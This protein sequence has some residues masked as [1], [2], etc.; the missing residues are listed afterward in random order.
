MNIDM[1][2]NNSICMRLFYYGYGLAL[3][4]TLSSCTKDYIDPSRALNEEALSSSQALTDISIGLQRTYSYL[5][6]SN[7]YN[8]VTA[9]GFVTNELLLRNEGNIPELQ[10]STGGSTVDGTNT[11]LAGLWTSSNK[12]IYDA[13]LVI[14]NA[15]KLADKNRASGIIAYTTVLKA[16]S[17]GDLAI[18]W[19]QVPAT[20]GRNASFVDRMEGYR[21][22]ISSI[23]SALLFTETDSIS[24][25][26]LQDIPAASIDIKNTL[27]ALK[28]RYSLYIGDYEEALSAASQVDLKK[29]SVFAYDNVSPNPIY[30][31]A[32]STNNVFQPKDEHLGLPEA[33][34][35]D[36]NDQR[37]LFYIENANPAPPAVR[38]K[39]FWFTNESPIP[40]YLPGEMLLIKAEAYARTS[41]LDLALIELNKVITKKPNDDV[42]GLGAA[43]PGLTGPY[44]E[45]ELLTLIY[46]HRCIELFMSGLKLEDMRRFN[47]PQTEMKRNF[48]PYPFVERDNNANTPADPTF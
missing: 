15:R 21:M 6:T 43:M 27:Y 22:A 19:E 40:V 12:I 16:L 10:L 7:I 39:G 9:N 2:K 35:P 8:K 32:T 25:A 37:V 28:A 24:N 48:F 26:F 5:R 31:F 29:V 44:S 42:Y 41:R 45:E 23:D 34:Y 14:Q 3:I 30:T 18:N 20:V 1:K 33:L 46:K 47:R 13:N 4:F 38:I 17:L 11:V 36:P